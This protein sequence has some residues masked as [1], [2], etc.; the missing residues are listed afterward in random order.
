MSRYDYLDLDASLRATLESRNVDELK[1]LVALLPGVKMKAP[2]KA[3]LVEAL[4]R[5]LL[6]GGLDQLW[7][8]LKALDQSA[9]AEAVHS[10]DG[11]FDADAFKAKCGALPVFVI[12]G[13][14]H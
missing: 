12:E 3:E 8:K 13:Q 4:E 14:K 9:V 5:F 10:N 2:R 11:T 6:D 7:T 1:G